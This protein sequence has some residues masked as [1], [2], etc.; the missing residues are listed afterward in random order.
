MNYQSTELEKAN[1]FKSRMRFHTVI[2]IIFVVI[3]VIA[4]PSLMDFIIVSLSEPS[5]GH[6]ENTL[7]YSNAHINASMASVAM[8]FATI[9]IGIIYLDRIKNMLRANPYLPASKPTMLALEFVEF[10]IFFTIIFTGPGWARIIGIFGVGAFFFLS[11]YRVVKASR[12]R[13]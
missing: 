7:S 9:T 5:Y 13:R 2:T 6:D 4:Y 12:K 8:I 10:M 11:L 3:L 1:L